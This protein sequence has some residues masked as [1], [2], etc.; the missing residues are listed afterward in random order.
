MS[1]NGADWRRTI[2]DRFE[3]RR[4]DVRLWARGTYRNRPLGNSIRYSPKLHQAN[5]LVVLFQLLLAEPNTSFDVDIPTEL[6]IDE[7]IL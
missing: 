6:L 7:K 1:S 2:R 5:G 4:N 3:N